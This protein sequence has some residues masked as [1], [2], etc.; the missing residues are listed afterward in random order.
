MSHIDSPG[1]NRVKAIVRL[2][3]RRERDSTGLF[4]V[5]G[6]RELESGLGRRDVVEIYVCETALTGHGRRVYDKILAEGTIPVTLVS[7]RVLEKISLRGN[8]SG[9]VAVVRQWEAPLAAIPTERALILVVESIEKPGNLG[10]MI[11]SAN[12]AGASVVV[13]DPTTDLFN[14]NVIRASM[15][16]LFTTPVAVASTAETIAF[17]DEHGIAVY[18][19]TPSATVAYYQVD[20][21]G[22]VA[23]VVGSEST[24]LTNIWLDKPGILIPMVGTIDSLNASVSAGIALFE[25]VR[26]RR[27]AGGA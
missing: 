19:T 9:F 14:S 7:E 10:G 27:N 24:G 6:E 11:R 16:T 1:N 2:R 3:K 15:G 25:A 5:E 12:A 4:L 17:L 8:P 22:P 13:A 21:S 26:Q 18:A 23:L 20:M